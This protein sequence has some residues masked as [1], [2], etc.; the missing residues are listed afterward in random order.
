MNA[1]HHARPLTSI[2]PILLASTLAL[3]S[4]CAVIDGFIGYGEDSDMATSNDDMGQI[5]ADMV[6]P[7]PTC[8]STQSCEDSSQTCV[9]VSK[10]GA[11]PATVCIDLLSISSD[12]NYGAP[13]SDSRATLERG[14]PLSLHMVQL[15]DDLAAQ[16][17]DFKS[18]HIDLTFGESINTATHTIPDAAGMTDVLVTSLDYST[19]A[20]LLY[21]GLTEERAAGSY[22]STY[23]FAQ[24]DATPT[25]PIEPNFLVELVDEDPKS[26]HTQR[27]FRLPNDAVPT[28]SLVSKDGAEIM[29]TAGFFCRPGMPTDMP[30]DMPLCTT[31]VMGSPVDNITGS[32][33]RI[34]EFTQEPKPVRTLDVIADTNHVASVSTLP[35]STSTFS[36]AFHPDDDDD[37]SVIGFNFE[38]S[39]VDTNCGNVTIHADEVQKHGAQIL[40]STYNGNTGDIALV[41][42]TAKD[43]SETPSGLIF[44]TDTPNVRSTCRPLGN[45]SVVQLLDASAN[46]FFTSFNTPGFRAALAVSKTNAD[47][48]DTLLLYDI[49]NPY[50]PAD[51]DAAKVNTLRS[52]QLYASSEATE[53]LNILDAWRV[54]DD[55]DEYIVLATSSPLSASTKEL[56]AFRVSIDGDILPLN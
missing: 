4:G 25:F 37:A 18:H 47:T 2:H 41:S 53:P 55:A 51:N 38:D 7:L 56:F 1:L 16:N 21:M 31:A 40:R 20:D 52:L 45:Y 49:T 17:G 12:L 32:K 33:M 27:F 22:T 6:T 43:G 30:P 9:K 35:G 36:V 46:E 24:D 29:L 42:L 48:T 8:G 15:P 13:S 28:S 44:F 34:D 19:N 23:T 54:D 39:N 5:T 10:N 3:L 50:Q 26:M 14:A 11:A